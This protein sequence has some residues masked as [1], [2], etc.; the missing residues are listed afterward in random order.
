MTF[1]LVLFACSQVRTD[2]LDGGT[3]IMLECLRRWKTDGHNIEVITSEEGYK[4]YLRG[5][6]TDIKY[7]VIHT[8]RNRHFALFFQYLFRTVK[9]SFSM[10]KFDLQQNRSIVFSGSDFLP[11]FIPALVLKMR[12]KSA[13]WVVAFYLS[14]PSPSSSDFRYRGRQIWIG[15]LYYLT[16]LVSAWL[17]KRYA[18]MIWVTSEADKE[19]FSG[20]TTGSARTILVRWGVDTKS[21]ELVSEP[22]K[23]DFDAVFV[24]RLH[25]QKGVLELA[26]IWSHVLS[27]KRD[28]KLAIIG[29][30]ELQQDLVAK[31][32]KL[33]LGQSVV[34]FGFLDGLDRIRILKTSRIFVHPA[35][36]DSGAI[37]PMEAMACGLPVV[38]FDLPALKTYY[39]QGVLLVPRGD[40]RAFA[41][42][43]VGVLDDEDLRRRIQKDALQLASRSD[44]DRKSRELSSVLESL[45]GSHQVC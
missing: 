31:L 21:P 2:I 37:A 5:G 15:F 35:V 32:S 11:D 23:K 29:T 42:A 38:C 40:L 1:D 34:L 25:P 6:L 13:K 17:A 33:K 16:Q 26:E 20:R 28:A 10:L 24:G 22:S 41:Q 30:G 43:V 12:V 44:W 14:T 4:V 8:P 27:L 18:D 7:T 45:V 19:R 36:H 3:R 9:L 39:P